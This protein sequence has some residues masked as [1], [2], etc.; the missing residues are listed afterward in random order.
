VVLVDSSIW[1]DL[2]RGRTTTQVAALRRLL[3]ADD[4]AL[5]P[6]IYQEIL[7]GA[8]SPERFAKLREYFR[9]LP[10]LLPAHPIETY[11]AAAEL[12]VAF[13]QR[14]LTPR[15]PHDCLVAR[16]AAEHAVPLLHDD[17][18]FEA[19]ARIERRLTFYMPIA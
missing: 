5:T 3:Q 9:S 15:S 16:I 19:L 13:R 7:Q 17:R 4:A 6:V 14:G 12:Y 10:F 8:A 18:D 1:I 2:L 11:A